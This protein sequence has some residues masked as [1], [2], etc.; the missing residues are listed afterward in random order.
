[1]QKTQFLFLNEKK[2]LETTE[3]GVLI[4][5]HITLTQQQTEKSIFT[6]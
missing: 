6:M 1:M 2:K 3:I 5:L 4:G